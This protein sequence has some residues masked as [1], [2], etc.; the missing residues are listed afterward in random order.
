M[1][2]LYHSI[3]RL[4][5]TVAGIQPADRLHFQGTPLLLHFVDHF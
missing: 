4:A 1:E 2:V 5:I 3:F